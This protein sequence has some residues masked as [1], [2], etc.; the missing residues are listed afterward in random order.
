MCWK[1][2]IHVEAVRR[3]HFFK[4]NPF[5][6][7]MLFLLHE[8]AEFGYGVPYKFLHGAALDGTAGLKKEFPWRPGFGPDVRLETLLRRIV[9]AGDKAGV[10]LSDMKVLFDDH[11]TRAAL[12]IHF[13]AF[14]YM[15]EQRKQ[16]PKL[17][18]G[19][20]K[21]ED[22]DA[23]SDLSWRDGLHPGID[24]APAYLQHVSVLPADGPKV[25]LREY[26]EGILMRLQGR[27][28]EEYFAGGARQRMLRH[29]Q[30]LIHKGVLTLEES[31]VLWS[32]RLGRLLYRLNK[33]AYRTFGND[34]IHWGGREMLRLNQSI[35][36]LAR[37]NPWA[38]I[39]EEE[40][41]ANQRLII[42]ISGEP[43]KAVMEDFA[44]HDYYGFKRENIYFLMD[45]AHPPLM[46]D[47]EIKCYRA[48]PS[49]VAE[50]I[51][52]GHGPAAERIVRPRAALILPRV[53][54]P[55][56]AFEDAIILDRSV[57][58]EIRAAFP[59]AAGARKAPE[60]VLHHARSNDLTRLDP[61]VVD[62]NRDVFALGLIHKG[63]P[64]VSEVV[65]APPP[66]PRRRE[67]AAARRFGGYMV[68]VRRWSGWNLNFLDDVALRRPAVRQILDRLR[69]L[70]NQFWTQNGKP[71]E[72]VLLNLMA[73][74]ALLEPY[75][76][77]LRKGLPVWYASKKVGRRWVEVPQLATNDSSHD[78]ELNA[79]AFCVEVKNPGGHGA[80]SGRI[81]KILQDFKGPWRSPAALAREK[82]DA[83]RKDPEFLALGVLHRFHIPLTPAIRNALDRLRRSRSEHLG[84]KR[85]PQHFAGAQWGSS[86]RR[87]R[88]WRALWLFAGVIPAHEILGHFL[89]ERLAGRRVRWSWPD[90]F[91][92][93]TIRV[94]GA[95]RYMGAVANAVVGVGLIFAL[96]SPFAGH[97]PLVHPVVAYLQYAALMHLLAVA[98]EI[99][100]PRGD[101]GSAPS[102]LLR[103]A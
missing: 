54:R 28:I 64:F 102:R 51:V 92:N 25:P 58:D 84:D 45:E 27:I 37:E 4:R 52:Y 99:L 36:K 83:M 57:V 3:N 2:I 24:M 69:A 5:W 94:S 96:G 39:S 76:E 66:S 63:H 13:Y 72:P 88:A 22:L 91:W 43:G 26:R 34:P 68:R 49:D 56:R 93:G 41:L 86:E 103:S 18:L 97:N 90:L 77:T 73:S 67:P 48:A 29:I 100:D 44:Q 75:A 101:F 16:R 78:P 59:P 21:R 30:R 40:A 35:R 87:R 82:L 70:R 17:T 61:D 23:I 55:G 14:R 11:F 32:V 50:P 9:K 79:A 46:Y 74:Y 12:I 53:V 89:A 6:F 60:V 71:E 15:T 33:N 95:A 20:L 47:P 31:G 7:W 38:N 81:R 42:H 10:D 62:P 1:A 85:P 8:S 98:A 80:A 19:K 65:E